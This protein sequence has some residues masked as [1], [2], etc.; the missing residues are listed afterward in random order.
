M[1]LLLKN[2]EIRPTSSAS[3]P[4]VNTTIFFIYIFMF[5]IVALVMV[6]VM[7]EIMIVEM[8]MKKISKIHFIIRS[9][10]IV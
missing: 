10:T 9:G 2:H 6:V 4:E 1:K 5:T 7:I 8:T 3:F